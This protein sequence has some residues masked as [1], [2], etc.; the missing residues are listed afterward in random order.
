[1]PALRTSTLLIAATLTATLTV[2]AC[3]AGRSTTVATITTAAPAAT[4]DPRSHS[5]SHATQGG[6]HIHVSRAIFSVL[7]V[8][9]VAW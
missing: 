3:T 5:N 9:A 4:G 6:I 7:T 2:A 8:N 1:M